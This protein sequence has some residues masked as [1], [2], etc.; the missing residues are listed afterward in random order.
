MAGID[1][2][3][4][5]GERFD[6]EKGRPS[7][8]SEL[9]ELHARYLSR[10]SGLLTLQ[11]QRLRELRAEERPAF[12]QLANQLKR[13]IE[14][15]LAEREAALA[16]EERSGS[17]ETEA[18]D[19]S[20]PGPRPRIGHRHP[21]TLTRRAIEDIFV[22]LGYTVEDGPEVET[23]YH[24]FEALNIGPEHP[25]RDAS[26]TFYISDD[27]VLRTQTSPVQIRTMERQPPPI[28]IICPGRVF[29]RDELDATHSPMF[30]Q[31]EG[32]VVDDGVT[33]GDLKGTLELL[34]RQFFGERTRTRLRPS[35]FP[36]TEPS[37]EVDVSCVFCESRGC[38][39]CKHT[40][41][42]EVMGA[43]MVHPAVYEY[44]GYD[45]ARYSGF[46]FGLGVDRYAMLKYGI[47]DIPL[48]FQ[49]D[50]RFLSQF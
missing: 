40:G 50:I 23:T 20:L 21:V 41:W 19:V 7:D 49:N 29:R 38:R 17:V 37:A 28:R 18:L 14:S 5:I 16:G 31:I 32:L 3:R 2:L 35:Y 8:R 42:I 25:S 24:N 12:G 45:A 27:V 34:H 6:R 9:E 43:G 33:F 15:E 30:H 39:V 44:V 36:F 47:D 10:K 22:A 26:D 11:L 1:D 48:L 13:R 4:Q 46:A